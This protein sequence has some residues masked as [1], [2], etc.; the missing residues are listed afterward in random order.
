MWRG[1]IG[2][3]GALAASAVLL[4]SGTVLADSIAADGDPTASGVQASVFLGMVAPGATVHRDVDL[5]LVCT[6]LYHVDPGQ[7]VTVF[8]SGSTIPAAGGSI[9]ATSATIGPVPSG[10]AD[11]TS[12][13]SG[14][15]SALEVGAATPSQVTIVAP[16]TPGSGY[17][18]TVTFD[19]SLSPVGVSDAKSITGFISVTFTL[20]VAAGDTVPPSF[21]SVPSAL[22]VVATSPAGA[23]VDFALPTATDNADPAPVVACDPAPGSLFPVG[24]TTVTCTATDAAGNAASI[25]FAVTVH[26]ASV[27]WGDP[28]HAG[29]LSALL[30]RTVPLK[31]SVV[32][33][34]VPLA[35]PASLR[36][37]A[38]GPF[39]A[40]AAAPMIATHAWASGPS[41]TGRW[42]ATL[43]TSGLGVGCH[44]VDLVAHGLT[45][46]SM[47]LDVVAPSSRW[48]GSIGRAHPD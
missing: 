47:E 23:N 9:T 46:G 20:G 18:Y 12:G 44:R 36:V 11:D 21:T 5:T 40:T 14:C 3:A 17:S 25:S 27:S 34:G 30:G 8:Q 38:C 48:G 22:D 29:Q 7:I 31:V 10:W 43:A 13:F 19:R 32:L 16:T 39:A 24:A 26:L 6:A 28:V 41:S 37:S 42:M 2:R 15:D 33:D 35:G 1:A 4:L 45:V